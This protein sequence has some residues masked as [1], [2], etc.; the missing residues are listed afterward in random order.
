MNVFLT[1]FPGFLGSALTERLVGR[2]ASVTCLVQPKYRDLAE[3]RAAEIEANHSVTGQIEL[4]EG[5]ITQSDL[6]LG[7]RVESLQSDIVEVYHLAAVYDLAVSREVAMAVNVEGTRNV[8]NFAEGCSNLERFQYVST[9]YVSG[10]YDGTFTEDHLVEGQQFNNYYETT[11]YLAEVAVQDR[12]AEGLP[13]TIYRPAITV[14]DSTTGETQKYDGPY[15]ILRWIL[16]QPSIAMAPRVGDPTQYEINVVPRDFVVDAIAYLSDIDE[17]VDTVY[18]LCDPDPPT[19]DEMLRVMA[20]ATKRRAIQVPI[21]KGLLKRSLERIPGLDIEP[22]TI[23]YFVHPTHYTCKNTLAD[24]DDEISC[25]AFG[26][27]APNL[28]SFVRDH[29]EITSDAMK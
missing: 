5:D 4:V 6:G 15:Y 21:P 23:D 3:Q 25:P 7:A 29:P 18:Q 22:A 28:V 11:K 12:M 1:G 16:Q 10:R 13:A 27:Y 14:G 9:C 2:G 8:L 19:V 20:R 26:T 24:L 17:S